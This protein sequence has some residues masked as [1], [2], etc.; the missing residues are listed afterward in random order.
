MD[1]LVSTITSGAAV[2]DLQHIDCQFLLDSFNIQI[3]SEIENQV[4]DAK[5]MMK[6]SL[7]SITLEDCNISAYQQESEEI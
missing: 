6:L 4:L 3:H 7:V 5:T 2:S 1:E